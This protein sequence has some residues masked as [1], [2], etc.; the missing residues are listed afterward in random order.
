MSAETLWDNA[1]RWFRQAR[2]DLEAA[3]ALVDA[4]RY[5]QAAFLSQ[6]SAEKAMKAVWIATRGALHW[7]AD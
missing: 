3:E 7:P 1:H 4:E 6:Q 2:D 5:A